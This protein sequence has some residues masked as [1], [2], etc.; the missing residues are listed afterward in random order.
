[1]IVPNQEYLRGVTWGLLRSGTDS[2][3]TAWDADNRTRH[4]LSKEWTNPSVVI[5][6]VLMVFGSDV[7]HSALAQASGTAYV[8]ICFSFGWVSYAFNT[9]I[10]IFGDGRL[11]PKP[12]YPAKVFALTS[13]YVQENRNWVVGRIVRDHHSWIHNNEPLLD[14]KIRITIYDVK[15]QERPYHFR[16]TR[17]HIWGALTILVQLVIASVPT[18]LTKGEEWGILLV[19]GVGTVLALL[20]GRMPQWKTEKLPNGF[21]SNETY[22]LTA[23]NGSRDIIIIQGAG[24]CMKLEEFAAHES[25][26]FGTP[27][28]KFRRFSAKGRQDS[29]MA[30]TKEIWGVPKG[31]FITVCSTMV[32]AVCW[33]LV[34]I[35]IPG[36]EGHTWAL[37]MV[38][39]IGFLHNAIVAGMRRKPKERNLP[40]I[41]LDSIL[42]RNIMD[43]LMDLEVSYPRCGAPL[44]REF[45]PGEMSV[46]ER[47]WWQAEPSGRSRTRYDKLRY[48][49]RKRRR[50][51]RS[52]QMDSTVLLS[53][54]GPQAEMIADQPRPGGAPRPL[55]PER[56][57]QTQ[58]IDQRPQPNKP[59]P[60]R[61]NKN[62]D[63]V[64]QDKA[65][66]RFSG[67]PDWD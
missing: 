49:Q 2:T 34:F 21:Q 67:P 58:S 36:I 1:M 4:D 32:L 22:A 52:M 54:G 60:S 6:T 42:T 7:I 24:H 15:R 10:G 65:L 44:V 37:I 55:S 5:A 53:P 17:L 8:P 50:R 9:L 43:G 46:E 20:T 23:G 12:D 51:P 18:I 13:K 19:T 66:P 35:T 30:M 48:E 57:R 56:S 26:M 41:F 29:S 63:K 3:R 33:L 38:G 47:E 61:T 40:L 31:F 16:Y 62:D 59:G 28:L 45:I 25:P 27:W 64:N 39:G 11:L 14:N